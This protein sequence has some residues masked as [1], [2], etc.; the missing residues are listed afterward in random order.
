MFWNGGGKLKSRLE[1]NPVLQKLINDNKPDIFTYGEAQINSPGN[2]N[3]DGYSCY[4]HQTK[5]TSV[6]NFRR[7]LAIFYLKKHKFRLSKSYA[8]AKYDIVWLRLQDFDETV[9]FC[10]FYSPGA[11]HPLPVRTKFYD[12]FSSKFSQFA[13][14]GKVYLMGDTNARLGSLLGDTDIH[15]KFVTNQNL[16][17]FK[18][19]LEFSGVTILNSVFCRGAPTYEIVNKKRS[20][21]DLCMTNSLKS[22]ENF[23]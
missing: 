17:L 18:E 23:K 21:I 11:H 14:L 8:A 16:P 2:L 5:P 1:S 12:I 7:G 4:L 20:I 13:S 22:V 10:F 6:D 19:F 3:L 15:G 9:H